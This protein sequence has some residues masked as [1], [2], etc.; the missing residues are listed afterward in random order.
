MLKVGDCVVEK[1]AVVLE[2]A[3]GPWFLRERYSAWSV[4]VGRVGDRFDAEPM[5]GRMAHAGV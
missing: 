5:P 2:R 1:R 4:G 3:E